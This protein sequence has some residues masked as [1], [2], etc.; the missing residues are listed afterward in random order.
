M[1]Y[2][3]NPRLAREADEALV[4]LVELV[5]AIDEQMNRRPVRVSDHSARAAVNLFLASHPKVKG[6]LDRARAIVERSRRA[7][8]DAGQ[9]PPLLPE[10]DERHLGATGL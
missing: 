7:S 9:V 8:F 1:T 10:A 3:D 6:Y 5:D 4:L 2:R